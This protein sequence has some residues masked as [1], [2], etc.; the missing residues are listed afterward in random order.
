MTPNLDRAATAAAET[1]IKY[2][3]TSS[4]VIPLPILKSMPSV[5]VLSFTEMAEEM[6][7]DRSDLMTMYNDRNKDASTMVREVNGKLRF[8]I[9]YNQ[10]LPFYM[11]QRSLARELGHI[12]LGH[13][14]SRPE[15]VRIAESL[16]FARHF[17]CPRPLIKAIQDAGINVSIE[18]LGSITGCY[19][20]CL[21]GI[22]KTPGTHVPPELN[23]IIRENFAD[24]VNNFIDCQP[25]LTRD[26]D[27]MLVNFGTYMDN[28]EE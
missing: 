13:D 27:S 10:R 17:L 14:G 12:V 26:D 21:V 16:C 8:F 3:V 5:L 24:Y 22:Q 9:A 28:Y 6:G 11:L 2:R 7:I 23:R 20:R 4:P 19:E 15:A 25:I 18:M 1:L